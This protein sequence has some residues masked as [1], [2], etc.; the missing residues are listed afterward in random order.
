[1]AAVQPPAGQTVVQKP[2]ETLLRDCRHSFYLVFLF[3]FI[4]EA[5]AIAPMIYMWNVFD[6][7]ITGRSGVT[8]IS[9]T[10]LMMGL[11]LFW[12]AI[13][14]MRTRLL[15]R[16]SLRIDWDLASDIFD[17]VF[18]RSVGRQMVNVQ[19]LMGDL[20]TVRQF[21][22]GTPLQALV[23]APFAVIYII[24]GALFHP[25]LAGFIL[26]S[27]ILMA[28][29]AYA[30]SKVSAPLLKLANQESAESS[31][32]AAVSIKSAETTL[33][34]GMLPA[35]RNRWYASHRNFLQLSVNASEATGLVG[36][37]GSFLQKALPS[38]QIALGAY[39]AINDLITGGMVIGASMLIS[40]AIF[41]LQRLMGSWSQIVG[42]RL[43]MERLNALLIED[44]KVA[45]RMSLPAP[46]GR[47]DVS[48]AAAVPAGS[49]QPVVADVSFT[50][51]PG[52]AVAIIGPSGSGKTSLTRMLVG[53]WRPRFGSVRLDGV[54]I[55]DWNHDEVGP[56]IGYV[57]QDIS[58][59]EA[60]IAEN[61]A[62]L[63]AVDSEKV[64]EAAKLV[65][66]HE[67]ILALPEGYDTML[68]DTGFALSGGQRQRIAIARAFYGNPKYIV[69]DE[70]NASLDEI[71]ENALL[72][73][74]TE[75]KAKGTSFAITTHRPR[76]MSVV[77]NLLVLRQG[78]QVGFGPAADMIAAVRNLRPVAA[79][80]DTTVEPI[81]PTSA[82]A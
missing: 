37:L 42:A 68:G 39:L 80:G 50:L 9:L 78:R 62:R 34:L 71:G 29:S 56:H 15:I 64:V 52:Q 45:G 38:L 55:S 72:K 73:A 67:A 43:A 5:L 82:S 40:R 69:M 27:M 51:L 25:Y 54:E 2:I 26:L 10:V 76:L 60:T 58:F 36:G 49:T 23:A 41:P 4:T 19:Q 3:T 66:M 30:N 14:W 79:A 44:R 16:I 20:V 48:G 7:V 59:L 77:D 53:V 22:T 6:R 57:P 63:G 75:L 11:Y 28:A 13:D 35:V 70:P 81:R 21:L 74:V 1:M 47:L 18:R 33:A 8:L 65:D 61:I 32:V 46:K 17:A 24:I 12:S 31:R